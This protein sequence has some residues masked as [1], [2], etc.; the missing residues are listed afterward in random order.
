[1]LTFHPTTHH[2]IYQKLYYSKYC[3]LHPAVETQK[4]SAR[5]KLLDSIA[6][7]MQEA[8]SIVEAMAFLWICDVLWD[9]VSLKRQHT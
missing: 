2:F 3:S 8:S 1:V 7:S 6:L 5:A 9:D 4:V